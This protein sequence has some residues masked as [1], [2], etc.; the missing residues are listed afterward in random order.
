MG[1]TVWRGGL[2]LFIKLVEVSTKKSEPVLDSLIN[3]LLEKVK[4]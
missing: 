2:F 1:K 4:T 3:F